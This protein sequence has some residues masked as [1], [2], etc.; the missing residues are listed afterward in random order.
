MSADGTFLVTSPNADYVPHINPGR[1]SVTLFRDGFYGRNDPILWPQVHSARYAFLAAVPKEVHPPHPHSLLWK[2]PAGQDFCPLAGLPARH[3]GLL[4][5]TVVE[6]LV[7]LG[8]SMSS[9]VRAFLRSHAAAEDTV[10]LQAHECA[11]RQASARLRLMPATFADQLVQ[12]AQFQRHWLICAAVM[13]FRRCYLNMPA[14]DTIPELRPA[15]LDLLGA[16]TTDPSVVQS[17][18]S[19]GLP[20]WFVRQ[21]PLIAPSIQVDQYVPF[22]HPAETSL[23]GHALGTPLYEGLLSRLPSSASSDGSCQRSTTPVTRRQTPERHRWARTFK[24]VHL[25]APPPPHPSQL[26]GRDKFAD[27]EHPW[28]PPPIPSWSQALLSVDRSQPAGPAEQRWAYWVPEPALVLGSHDRHRQRRYVTNWVRACPVWLYVLRH[29]HADSLRVSSQ[30]WRL[31]LNG[32][33]DDP[34]SLTKNGQRYM[35]I[36]QVFGAVLAEEDFNCADC[37]PVKWHQYT[38][39]ECPDQLCS[40]VIWE[41]HELAFRNEFWALDRHFRRLH[42]P[43]DQALRE[44]FLGAV[45]PHH[46]IRQLAYLPRSD[47]FGLFSPLPQRRVN[48][49][50]AFREVL[51]DWPDFPEDLDG[52]PL[53]RGSDSSDIIEQYE[54][55]LASFYT[56]AFFAAAG[57]APIVPHLLPSG[58]R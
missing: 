24:P 52:A 18:M 35:E 54:Y 53:L 8:H 10:V 17:F 58:P 44:D 4:S 32:I 29:P 42:N 47:E 51:R 43:L 56:Q 49:L 25:R 50:N 33:P 15:Q 46:G 11:M 14:Q 40:L 7:S 57:R 41:L 6:P 28:M 26:R 9:D 3:F 19:V 1:V 20:V 12:V 2:R 45:F 55:G 23:Q 31:F 5:P 13:Q 37:G 36:K 27:F 39:T 16:W 34:S 38:F 21:R 48:S 30:T 22:L